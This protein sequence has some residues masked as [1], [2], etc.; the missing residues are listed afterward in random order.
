MWFECHRDNSP[1]KSQFV[2][3]NHYRSRYGRHHGALAHTEQQ[4]LKDPQNITTVKKRMYNIKFTLSFYKD[5]N[6]KKYI[7]STI[8]TTTCIQK[9]FINSVIA[10]F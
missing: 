8:T 2:K 5:K 7:R 9:L 6:P 1:S 4:A 10:F 3:V